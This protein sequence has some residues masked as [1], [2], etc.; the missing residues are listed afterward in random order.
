MKVMM[1]GWEFPPFSSG[2]LGTHC[3]GLVNAM[4]DKEDID[5][6]F[7]MPDEE[8]PPGTVRK[9]S[10]KK[11][12]II[13]IGS[14]IKPYDAHY[15]KMIV[16]HGTAG[17]ETYSQDFFDNVIRYNEVAVQ[18]ASQEEFDVIHCHDWMTFMAGVNLKQKT[19]KPLVVTVHSTE[20]DRTGDNPNNWI[21]H[22]EWTGTYNA[23]KVITVSGMMKE[24]LASRYGTPREKIEVI[25]NAVR[26][27]DFTPGRIKSKL[28]D[29]IVLF[30]GRITLQKGLD[31]FLEA[32]KLVLE[33]DKSV[34]FVIVGKGDQMY[35][36]IER[37]VHLGIM[38]N[39]YFVGFA[40][41]IE[42]FYKMADVYV[43]P[44]VS[45]PFGIV[46][47][48]AMTCG[49]PVIASKRSGVIEVAKHVL[50]VDFWDTRELANKI[51]GIVSYPVVGYEMGKNGMEEVR[52]ITW[53]KTAEQTM[54][55]YERAIEVAR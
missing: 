52:N 36:M 20:F 21:S 28:G 35:K 25:Y 53:H 41:S 5:I 49:T 51:L 4:S 42:E 34:K 16:K 26:H 40:P 30:L 33:K 7:V 38:N 46:A 8:G 54:H 14:S 39:V 3:Y 18:A 15:G 11:G 19:G 22:V 37:A 1:L 27:E 29:K 13:K 23:D 55:V 10:M 12:R 17:K 48:E 31:Y 45:E 32:A 47:L 43:M 24:Q 9:L 2:G 50:T 44:S 6:T